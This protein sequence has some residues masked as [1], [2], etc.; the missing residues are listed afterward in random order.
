MISN[1][2]SETPSELRSEKSSENYSE[3]HNECSELY[4]ETPLEHYIVSSESSLYSEV[5]S[6]Y[7]EACE[8]PQGQDELHRASHCFYSENHAC[9]GILGPCMSPT[10]VVNCYIITLLAT[11]PT[12]YSV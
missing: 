6:T 11:I 1:S 5:S 9:R 8:A 7:S 12:V 3:N 4:S 10:M 2:Y